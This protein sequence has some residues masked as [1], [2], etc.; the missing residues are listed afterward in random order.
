MGEH[1]F[2]CDICQDVCPWNRSAPVTEDL[3]FQPRTF[4]AGQ[5][6]LQPSLEWLVSMGQ[7]EFSNV[8]QGSPIKR[9]K[10]RGM[11]RNACMALGNSDLAPEGGARNRVLTLLSGLIESPDS[12]V[13]ESAQW[14]LSRIQEKAGRRDDSPASWVDVELVRPGKAAATTKSEG[15]AL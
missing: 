13:A 15:Q 12:M 10:W 3:E 14:A 7:Q 6:L 4:E 1:V 2:G 11:V 5:S 9:A 8:F